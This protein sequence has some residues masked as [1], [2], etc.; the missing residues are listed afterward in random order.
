M[1]SAG[2]EPAIQQPQTYALDSTVTEIG[3]LK[4]GELKFLPVGTY[5]C[6]IWC[7]SL[8]EYIG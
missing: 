5:A 3:R 7:L 6:E 1:S 8:G 2:F 4:Y